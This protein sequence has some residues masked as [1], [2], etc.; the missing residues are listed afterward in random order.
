MT[1]KTQE[2]Y[3]KFMGELQAEAVNEG[4]KEETIEEQMQPTMDEH[5]GGVSYLEVR[6]MLTEFYPEKFI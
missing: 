5:F 3:D 2:E 4:L 1:I 6:Q